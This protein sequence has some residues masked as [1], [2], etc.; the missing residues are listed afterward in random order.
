M[1]DTLES[2]EIEPL[3]DLEEDIREGSLA[4]DAWRQLRRRPLFW[5]CVAIIL[6]LLLAS[7]FP[8]L[9]TSIDP[10]ASDQRNNLQGPSS[11][12]WFGT[13]LQGRDQWSRVVHG[14]RVSIIIAFL[15]TF[16]AAIIAMLLGSVA[17]YYGGWIDTLISRVTDVW[18]AIPAVLGGIVMLQVFERRNILTVSLVL[19]V[20]GWPTMLRLVRSSVIAVR[21]ADYVDAA[22]ALGASD[23]R[24]V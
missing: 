20:F 15:V 11:E 4:G 12:H 5:I 18:F 8:Q 22:R 3:D 16:T 10:Q 7:A 14:A 19:I 21:D 24:I 2:S 9:F 1:T 13:D 17:G 23:S 6:L